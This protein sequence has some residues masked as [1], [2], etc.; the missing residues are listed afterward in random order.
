M[1]MN[2]WA[3]RVQRPQISL[4]GVIGACEMSDI[5]AENLTWVNY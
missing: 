2:A 3:H 5:D 1:Y 4:D